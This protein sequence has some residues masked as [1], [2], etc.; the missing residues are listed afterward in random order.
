MRNLNL[1]I[2]GLV[3]LTVATVL[4]STLLY[5]AAMTHLEG[6]PR[7]F[8]QSL[9]FVIQTMTTTGFGE[10]AAY[11]SSP[12]V[13]LI[14]IAIM[15]AGITL[16][17]LS[18]PII[19]TPWLRE[20]FSLRPPSRYRGPGNHVILSRHSA[21]MDS[22]IELLEEREIPYVL[23]DDREEIVN[24]LYREKK[25][26]LFGPADDPEILAKAGADRARIAILDN[27]DQR[28]ASIALEM[29]ENIP[30]LRILAVAGKA[31]RAAHLN[32]AGV[33]KVFYPRS[34]IGEALAHKVLSGLGRGVDLASEETDQIE[35]EEFPVLD[36]SPLI[37]ATL[38]ESNIRSRTGAHVVGI[39][40]QGVF[41]NAPEPDFRIQQHDILVAAGTHEQLEALSG[42]SESRNRIVQR[43]QHPVLIVGYGSEGVACRET[44]LEHGV[45]P[46]V[47]NDI[48]RDGVDLVGDGMDPEVLLEAGVDEASTMIITVSDDDIATMVTLIARRLNSRMEILT[49]LHQ[50]ATAESIYRAGASYVHSLDQISSRMLAEEVLG[51]NLLNYRLNIKLRRCGVG[52]LAGKRLE[53][54]G[55]GTRYRI[56]IL[57]VKRNGELITQIP[58]DFKFQPEDEILV[59]G[60]G[61]NVDQFAEAYQIPEE[62]PAEATA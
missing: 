45:T 26:V 49:Q 4:L 50:S 59:V 51:E 53:D 60:K 58:R 24:Q 9:E 61:E 11:W 55:I 10:D 6:E 21:I 57:G 30:E 48:D 18:I 41:E 54:E 35:V 34:K 20:R 16:V 17:F 1:R 56:N 27:P 29:Q 33:D 25:S 37:G 42:L 36:P 2:W 8:L 13:Y 40:R 5:Q 32:S 14:V 52:E 23:I 39:W 28:T 46:F 38:R 19:V 44:L 3:L 31:N 47:I 15:L 62:Q 43:A 12:W 7:S 22:L